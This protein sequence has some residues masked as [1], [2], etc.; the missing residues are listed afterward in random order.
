MPNIQSLAGLTRQLRE[1]L[2]LQKGPRDLGWMPPSRP[3]R[4]ALEAVRKDLGGSDDLGRPPSADMVAAVRRFTQHRK[5]ES[6]TQLKYVCYGIT[7][8]LD[9]QEGRLIERAPL[10]Q[11]LL[12][13]VHDRQG[14]AKQFRRCYQGLLSAYF[15]FQR[16]GSATQAGAANWRKL[17]SFLNDQLDGVVAAARSRGLTLEWLDLLMDH[18]NLLEEGPCAR[19][20]SAMRKGDTSELERACGGLEISSRSWVWHEAVLAYVH[21]VTRAEDPAFQSELPGMLAMVDGADP[22]HKLP[23]MVARDAM[24]LAVA[25]YARCA[26]RPEQS[27]LRDGCLRRIGNP[28]LDRAAW[29]SAVKSEPAR[30]MVESWL[31]RRLI[32]DFFELLAHD[33]AADLRRLNYWLKWEP[34]ITDMWFVLG[35]DAQ[36]NKTAPFRALRERMAGRDRELTGTSDHGNNAFVM[37]IGQLLVIEFGKTKNACFIMTAADFRGNLG[38]AELSVYTLKQ[39]IASERLSHSGSWEYKFDLAMNRLLS[40]GLTPPRK[41][42]AHQASPVDLTRSLPWPAPA[43]VNIKDELDSAEDS[44]LVEGDDEETQE[45]IERDWP[46]HPKQVGTLAT[47]QIVFRCK[48]YSVGVEDSR[49]TG[50]RFWV[51][52]PSAKTAPEIAQLMYQHGFA[53]VNGVGYYVDAVDTSTTSL[54]AASSPMPAT[55]V[56]KLPDAPSNWGRLGTLQRE[57]LIFRCKKFNVEIVDLRP[58]LDRIWVLLKDP[59]RAP[60][61]HQ[62]LKQIGFKFVAGTGFY[63]DLQD[64]RLTPP[65][66]ASEGSPVAK[67]I[68]DS[69][70]GNLRI[71]CAAYGVALHDDREHD[72][73]VWVLLTSDQSHPSFSRRLEQLGFKYM[74]GRGYYLDGDD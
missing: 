59:G 5:V 68:T 3:M 34:R 62:L 9:D 69:M 60:M 26:D 17:R 16:D 15:G 33:G 72:G 66:V 14:Q 40:N 64:S 52:L 30:Q 19:Y 65:I 45:A 51:L 74:R 44:D 28:W 56:T 1:A 43:V 4:Q 58:K 31:K 46:K 39:R 37:R 71:E 6:F 48:R 53:H 55:A 42:D 23:E 54:P 25:R 38:R 22:L 61:I 18:R 47:E 36:T 63:I 24:A 41:A 20:S 29:D 12:Q 2:T 32:K 11:Q 10:L 27:A 57:Q 13:L 73:P 35:N 7:V 50:G 67:K 70:L 8:P 49:A 21:E